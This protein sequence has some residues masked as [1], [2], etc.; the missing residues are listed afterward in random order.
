MLYCREGFDNDGDDN[1]LFEI[2]QEFVDNVDSVI[3]DG[4][5]Y[6]RGDGDDD[7]FSGLEWICGDRDDRQ[8]RC[9]VDMTLTV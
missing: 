5:S 4:S 2:L 8:L 1:E 9:D 7:L 3:L 6:D